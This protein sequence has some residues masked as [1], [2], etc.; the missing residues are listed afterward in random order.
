MDTQS[1]DRSTSAESAEPR[2]GGGNWFL[3]ALIFFVAYVLS[4]GPVTK[5][6][7]NGLLPR[8][9]VEL[10]YAPINFLCNHFPPIARFFYWYLYK[11]WGC[12]RLIY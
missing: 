11:L 4:I 2:R 7:D 1:K 8:A 10:I 9:A 3:W 6:T 5:L 12:F